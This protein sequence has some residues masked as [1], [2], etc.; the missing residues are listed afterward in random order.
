MYAY[1][2]PDCFDALP[3]IAFMGEFNKMAGVINGLA[4]NFEMEKEDCE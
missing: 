4:T 2:F 1:L 3:F